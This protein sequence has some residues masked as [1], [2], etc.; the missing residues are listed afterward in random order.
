MKSLRFR[1]WPHSV[2]RLSGLALAAAALVSSGCRQW[3]ADTPGP[4][5]LQ[6]S[7]FFADG[8]S[9]RPLVPGTV[10]RGHLRDDDPFFAGR[11]DGAPP[12]E[13]V[14]L[15]SVTNPSVP[16]SKAKP[17]DP[18]N[19]GWVQEF[20]F[21][22]TEAVLK[23]GQERYGVY[24]SM[25]HGP[26]GNGYGKIVER[27]FTRAPSYITDNSRAYEHRGV[28]VRLSEVPV[29]Y[30][31]NVISNGYGAMGQ[32]SAQINPKDRWAIVS[33]VRALQNSQ[34]EPKAAVAKK[35]GE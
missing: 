5:P 16:F 7:D 21:E 25:C 10:A 31:Y 28:K 29:G 9:A 3:M 6:P 13:A 15:D 12:Y 24:C 22:I 11:L 35:D 17:P 34:Q 32:Y 14:V 8:R 4:T 20:P 30:I 2:A 26:T 18:M 27:G 19:D 23:R 1:D 33:Y